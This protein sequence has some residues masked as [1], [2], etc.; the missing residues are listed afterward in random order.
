M[1]SPAEDTRDL[2]S[3]L[4]YATIVLTTVGAVFVF[5][6]LWVRFVSTKAHGWDDYFIIG[7]LVSCSTIGKH[8][9]MTRLTLR[10]RPVLCR[11]P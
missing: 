8:I 4:L 11:C 10:R 5:V 9:K 6:R 3:S 7:S 1:A 2:S